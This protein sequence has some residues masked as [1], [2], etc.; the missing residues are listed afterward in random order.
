MLGKL[1]P[2]EILVILGLLLL[3]FG[4]KR[5]PDIGRSLGKGLKE[6][7]DAGKDMKKSIS[8]DDDG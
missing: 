2:M 3:V 7:R 1:G 8:L 5:L 6:L 4:P